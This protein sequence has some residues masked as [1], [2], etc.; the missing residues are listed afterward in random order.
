M[1][2]SLDG[3][4]ARLSRLEACVEALSEMYCE[5]GVIDF[6]TM[7]HGSVEPMNAQSA[8]HR[9]VAKAVQTLWSDTVQLER[10]LKRLEV[11]HVG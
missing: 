4:R 7:I 1:N 9:A 6:V 5:A 3:A 8:R 2:E 10:E 11:S